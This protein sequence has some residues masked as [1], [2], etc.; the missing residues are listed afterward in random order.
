MRDG[1][2]EK[3]SPSPAERRL[4]E[5][6]GIRS[7]CITPIFIG[8]RLA[9]FFGAGQHPAP[10]AGAVGAQHLCSYLSS[11]IQKEE[12][13]AENDRLQYYDPADGTAEL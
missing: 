8:A 9:R 5:Q 2:G 11:L 6:R 12:L 4:L 10:L 7:L 3:L 1:D 13:L